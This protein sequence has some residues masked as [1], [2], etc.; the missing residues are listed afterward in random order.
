MNTANCFLFL[1]VLSLI[2]SCNGRTG[3]SSFADSTIVDVI[4]TN[5][6]LLFYPSTNCLYSDKT[7]KKL[8]SVINAGL[9]WKGVLDE[10]RKLLSKDTTLLKKDSLLASVKVFVK[11]GDFYGNING[12]EIRSKKKWIKI[13]P[14]SICLYLVA[15]GAKG[16]L[17]GTITVNGISKPFKSENYPNKSRFTTKFS[18]KDFNTSLPDRKKIPKQDVLKVDS[19][20]TSV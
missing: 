17:E 20:N 5:D 2:F 8:D 6:K 9:K 4:E 1:G 7:K 10:T 11:T 12:F 18:L 19:T 13:F 15:M 3:E 16:T 14:D